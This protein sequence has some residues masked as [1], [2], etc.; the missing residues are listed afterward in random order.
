[1]NLNGGRVSFKFSLQDSFPLVTLLL[2]GSSLHNKEATDQP[3]V[4]CQLG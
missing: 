2:A 1:M 4:R 3:L